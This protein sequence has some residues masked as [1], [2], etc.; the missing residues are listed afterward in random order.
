[1]VHQRGFSFTDDSTNVASLS[2]QPTIPI[3]TEQQPFLHSID[4]AI[5]FFQ[6]RHLQ[7]CSY[8]ELYQSGRQVL[9]EPWPVI[10]AAL[11]E[12]QVSA[13]KIPNT[14]K[15]PMRRL[16]RSDLL[17]SNILILSPRAFKI[18]VPEY[19]TA[20]IFDYATEYARLVPRDDANSEESA[21]W[22]SH[23]FRRAFY[24]Y[25]RFLDI[26]D[27]SFNSLFNGITPQA[28]PY[29]ELSSTLPS[30]CSREPSQ[31]AKSAASC[32]NSLNE[33]MEHLSAR[34]GHLEPWKIHEA[35]RRQIL[36]KLMEH[37]TS[38]PASVNT[39]QT[40]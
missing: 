8:Q 22:T 28:P 20:L 31:M 21:F 13:S 39:G 35:R 23:D 32:L 15:R 10:F 14:M 1:M 6:L 24:V 27:E 19:G 37:H 33:T 34:F 5:Y 9:E 11:R 29:P 40:Q 7:S 17:Y 12:M 30:L 3:S 18:P 38:E 2:N 36:L 26:L 25:R 4:P 16:V